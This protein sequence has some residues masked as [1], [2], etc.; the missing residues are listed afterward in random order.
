MLATPIAYPQRVTLIPN[1]GIQFL[2]FSLTPVLDAER[3]GKFV[4]QT[5]NG[6]LLRLNYHQAKDRYFLPVAP[7]NRPKWYVRNSAFLWNNHCGC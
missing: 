1:S 4:R 7:A 2:D 6:P 3:P 5:A